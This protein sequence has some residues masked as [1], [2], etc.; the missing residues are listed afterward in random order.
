MKRN[1]HKITSRDK[2][3]TL[4]IIKFILFLFTPPGFKLFFR[5]IKR[6]LIESEVLKANTLSYN[7]WIAEQTNFEKNRTEFQ[8]ISDSISAKPLVSIVLIIDK[9][10]TALIVDILESIEQQVYTNWELCV[11]AQQETAGVISMISLENNK[12][13]RIITNGTFADC[14]NNAVKSATGEYI[15]LLRFGAILTPNCL[16]EFVKFID[17][18]E[19]TGLIYTDEDLIGN[20]DRFCTPFFKPDWAPDSILSRNY[21]GESFFITQSLYLSIQGFRSVYGLSCIYDFIF[22]ASKATKIEHIG[23]ILFH[24]HV[25]Q[26]AKLK[27]RVE[28]DMRV[29]LDAINRQGYNGTIV[30]D[31]A[32]PGFYKVKYEL[33]SQGKVTILI[34]SKDQVQLLKTAVDSI[35]Q[36]TNYADYEIIVINNNSED[37]GFFEFIADYT[38]QHQGVFKSVDANIPF[39]F[40][41]LMNLGVN[42]SNGEYILFLN[43]DVEILQADWLGT[44][45][46]FAQ[47]NEIGAIGIKLLYP[48]STIQHAGITLTGMEA[49]SHIFVGL[50]QNDTAHFNFINSINNYSAVTAACLLCRKSVYEAVGGMDENLDVEYN[51]VDLCLKFLEYGLYNVYLPDVEVVHYESATRGHPFRSRGAYIKHKENLEYFKNKWIKFMDNDPYWNSQNE[52]SFS[53]KG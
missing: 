43:N 11:G 40:S 25:A 51:D 19:N 15:L 28:S 4:N 52:I 10:T 34:P 36:K 53:L 44:M 12:K 47:R 42:A 26:P 8:R 1:I 27:I 46:S 14:I 13:K 31:S 37:Q 23:K 49:T 18:K 2:H 33:I 9:D 41:K 16:S 39:N 45:V 35:L 29:I 50:P 7:K 38:A 30:P 32:N 17:K 24:N 48:D 6:Q 21:I 5:A 3:A 22:R 20:N